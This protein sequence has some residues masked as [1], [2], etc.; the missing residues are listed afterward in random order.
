MSLGDVATKLPW[1]VFACA[2]DKTPVVHT[3]FKAATR[4]TNEI[5]KQ[6][7]NPSAVM[8]GVPTG[9]SSGIIGID[10]DIKAGAP[11][12]DWLTKHKNALPET[13]T[14]KTQ[15]GGLH[16][17]FKYPDGY[18]IRNSASRI[19]PGIDV[20]GN[21][22]Y[23]IFPPSPGYVVADDSDPAVMPLWLIK[24]C[25]KEIPPSLPR[26]E[27]H[28]QEKYVQT[29]LDQEVLSVHRAPEGTRN[30]ALNI[31][32][33]KLGTLVGAG[34]LSRGTVEAELTRAALG[35][36]LEPLET[37]ATIRS[38]LEHGI[39][40]PR[41]I[42][43]SNG[44]IHHSAFGKPK[45]VEPETPAI[46][47]IRY[48]EVEASLDTMD[49]VEDF[50]GI[51]A[52]SVLYG[53]SNSG[54]TFFATN[55]GFYIACGWEWFSRRVERMAVI[56]VALEGKHGIT[57][58]IAAFKIEYGVEDIPFGIVTVPLDLCNSDSDTVALV[59]A[60]KAEGEAIGF[61]IGLIV[62]DTLSRAMSG[63]NENAPD[64]MGALV[65][66]GDFIRSEIGAHLM[67][68]HHCG[69]DQAKGAR[70]HS[71]LR[72]ATDT[73]IEVTADGSLHMARVTKQR[74][75]ECTGEFPFTLKVVELGENKRGKMLTSCVVTTGAERQSAVAPRKRLTAME[76]RALEVLENVCA[77]MGRT[78]D[79]GVPSGAASV[80][81]KWWRERFYE[82]SSPG[83]TQ[84][85]KQ[86]AFRRASTSLL[87]QHIVGMATNRVW[88]CF[89]KEAQPD[90]GKMSGLSGLDN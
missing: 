82:S 44:A 61:K 64:D 63:G 24:A 38:G 21:G 74:E 30:H 26:Y 88:I 81:D 28:R 59:A 76:Q 80:P 54:K 8:I 87:N 7:A 42:T 49:L 85:S 18:D 52:M 19:A 10:V 4:D 3:G 9:L 73:E 51:G 48:V 32:A 2:R 60:I 11:G 90:I 6:F 20:R 89:K 13:R 45:P 23:L 69:K 47:I 15:S 25:L 58:R 55:L 66:N 41:E 50:L 5:L 53:E 57:N 34:K 84:E 83:D 79:A 43:Q 75:Y 71:S 68:V 77:S 40:N 39:Q 46:K 22:G 35:A 86:K 37:E 67:Y 16:L 72:A 12:M 1:P 33:V 65:R 17:I 31:A 14:H 78:G 70:G 27:P 36:G 29:A 56:Y 62:I